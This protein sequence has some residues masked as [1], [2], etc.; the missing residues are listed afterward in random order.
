[1]YFF[2]FCPVLFH[3]CQ[4]S[5]YLFP[6]VIGPFKPEV[7]IFVFFHTVL[8]CFNYSGPFETK[9]KEMFLKCTHFCLLRTE[10]G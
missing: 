1:M 8:P 9:G 5:G 7:L 4:N 2:F 10:R 3:L 6:V